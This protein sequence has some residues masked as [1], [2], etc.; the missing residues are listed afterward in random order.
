MKLTQICAYYAI[1]L[2]LLIVGCSPS[3]TEQEIN[4]STEDTQVPTATTEPQPSVSSTAVTSNK[5]QLV[6]GELISEPEQTVQK[7]YQAIADKNCVRAIQLRPLYPEKQ[8]EAIDKVEVNKVILVAKADNVAVVYL[9]VSY[10]A[11]QKPNSFF[12]HAKL[13]KLTGKWLLVNDSFI[14]AEKLKLEEYLKQQQ[15][16]ASSSPPEKATLPNSTTLADQAKS[17]EVSSVPPL[18]PSTPVGNSRFGSTT[19][20]TTCWTPAELSGN[21]QDKTVHRPLKN[22]DRSPPALTIPR[23]S[24]PPVTPRLRNSIRRVSLDPSQKMVA[25]TFDLCE[26][27]LETTGYDV[28]IINYLRKNHLQATF[29]AGGKWMRSHPDKTMQLMADPLFEVGNHTWTHGNLRVITG[30]EMEEQI[31]WTQAEYELLW[32]QLYQRLETKQCNV[33]LA[34]MDNIPQVP[35]TF[36][37]PYGTCHTQALDFLAQQGL[38]AIQWDVVTADPSSGQTAEN[39]AKIVLNQ[40]RSGSIIIAHANGRGHGTAKAL[41]LF[42]PPLQQK[43]YRFVTVSELLASAKEVVTTETCY[44]LKPGDNLRY[45]K[46]FGK[47]TE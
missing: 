2:G 15:I 25:L 20:L 6:S 40:V 12:G 36:R 1:I 11:D 38:P 45:D 32:N 14:S 4:S 34:E 10:Q 44:E 37:F 41:P 30:Q 21:P 18:P 28:E 47:G 13:V 5:D 46:E 16:P 31:L 26:R 39:I 9:D 7:F 22:P 35:L 8:C 24:N 27:T 17:G 43:G 33:P 3:S 29:Y 42:I 23:Y 19:I